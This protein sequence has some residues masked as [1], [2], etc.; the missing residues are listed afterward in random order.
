MFFLNL[1]IPAYA[2]GLTVVGAEL[3]SKPDGSQGITLTADHVKQGT[4]QFQIKNLSTNLGHELL[5]VTTD[6]APAVMQ[7]ARASMN[8][9]QPSPRISNQACRVDLF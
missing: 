9:R 4:V 6:L 5:L 1:A 7:A 2:T 3:W 8:K